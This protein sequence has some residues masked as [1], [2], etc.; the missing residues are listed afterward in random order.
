VRGCAWYDAI[1]GRLI[2]SDNFSRAGIRV[3]PEQ[4]DASLAFDGDRK[5]VT[6]QFADIKS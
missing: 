2:V 5:T 6:A 4:A 1:G 3:T